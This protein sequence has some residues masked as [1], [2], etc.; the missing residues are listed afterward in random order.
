MT[1]S[2]AVFG[3]IVIPISS[4]LACGLTISN[5]VIYDIVM[6]KYNKYNK[7]HEKDQQ[8]INFL[9]NYIRE[10]GRII[11]LN[12]QNM[13]LYVILLLG[14]LMKQKMNLFCKYEHETKIK[15]F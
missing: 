9:I 7:Q 11:L 14:T 8:L 10:A 1:L 15:F 13:D 4:S 12:K 3:L 6:Q 2:V 5:K